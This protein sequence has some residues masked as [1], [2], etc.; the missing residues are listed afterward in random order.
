[1]MPK[2]VY[3]SLAALAFF[4]AALVALP[5]PGHADFYR[6]TDENGVVHYSN[7]P[8]E[9]SYE[10]HQDEKNY[11]RRPLDFY[12]ARAGAT[13]SSY[14]NIIET[15]SDIYGIKSSLIKAVIK[16][17]S[18][19]NP[20]AMSRAGAVGLMQLMP[21]TAVELGVKNV[22]DPYDNVNGGVKH[23]SG[24][25]NRFGGDL[26]LALAAYN[27]GETSVKRYGDIPPFKE[28]RQY[29]KRVLR[30]FEEYGG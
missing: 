17:E 12:S 10:W 2:K 18:N 4:M 20:Y 24:L 25:L 13:Q 1:M 21:D 6:Y 8:T 9:S 28:T 26:S 29:V 15:V 16:A 5:R 30:F 23:L 14:A 11:D 7:V 22:F 19:F 3:I 27:A